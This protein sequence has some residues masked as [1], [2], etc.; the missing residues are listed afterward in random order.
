MCGVNDAT[1]KDSH[2]VPAF[3]LNSMIGKRYKEHSFSI[4]TSTATIDEYHGRDVS[5]TTEIK[6]HHHAVDF[7]LCP[8]CESKLGKLESRLSEHITFKLRESK[9]SANYRTKSVG[10][11]TFKELPKVN[12][13]DFNVF[14]LSII[15]RQAVQR[16]VEDGLSILTGHDLEILRLIVNSYLSGDEITYQGVCGQFGLTILTADSFGDATRNFV[17]ALDDHERPYIFLMNEFWVLAYSAQTFAESQKLSQPQKFFDIPPFIEHLN[18]PGKTPNIVFL[19]QNL[20]TDT[21]T[22]WSEDVAPNYA[23]N[24][25][26][27]ILNANAAITQGQLRSK[28]KSKAVKKRRKN[29]KK[30]RKAARKA[31]K[32]NRRRNRK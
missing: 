1:Q 18:Y 11:L 31:R 21:L 15:W 7:Y 17:S 13:D 6:E 20:W 4:D 32:K 24:L 3:L 19:S 10:G 14:F 5:P 22:R 2:I 27:K 25:N 28:R 12:T 29:A 30:A 16:K 8:Q 26:Q 23:F 9:F